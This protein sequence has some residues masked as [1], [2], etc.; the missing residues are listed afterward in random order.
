MA[1]Q[2]GHRMSR[3]E[4]KYEKKHQ[5]CLALPAPTRAKGE[6]FPSWARSS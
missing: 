6:A 4:L 5:P 1:A 2:I 3:F